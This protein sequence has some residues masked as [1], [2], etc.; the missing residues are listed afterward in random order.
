MIEFF[1]NFDEPVCLIFDEFDKYFNSEDLLC[2]LD[3]IEKQQK[4]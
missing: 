1:K 3:G 4:C 2:L